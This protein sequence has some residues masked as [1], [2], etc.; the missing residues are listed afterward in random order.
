LLCIAIYLLVFFC[1]FFKASNDVIQNV[2]GTMIGFIFTTV[3]LYFL[4]II[5]CSFEDFN[6]VSDD[7]DEILSIYTSPEEEYKKTVDLNGSH[8][9]VAY[10]PLV[11]NKNFTFKVNDS[12]EGIFQ[13]DDFIT[14]NFSTIF[15]AHNGSKKNNCL[16]VRLNKVIN[17]KD[18]IITFET[19]RSTYYNHLL[20]NRAIDY[21]LADKLTLRDI[22]EFGPKINPP[23]K[24]KMSNHIGINALVFLNDGTL[25]IPR[26]K[27]NST[28]SKKM[29]TSSIAVKLD[30]PENNEKVTVEYLLKDN[31]KN[32]LVTRAKIN[33]EWLKG[34][35]KIIFLGAGQNLYEAGKPQFYY[36]VI[37]N[38]INKDDYLKYYCDTSKKKSSGKMDIDKCIYAVDF[39][40]LKFVKNDKLALNYFSKCKIKKTKKICLQYEKSFACNLWHDQQN[41]KNK[42]K[43][44]SIFE[45]V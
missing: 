4:K 1:F 34:D 27:G 10:H 45:I 8:A 14:E 36:K 25:L 41:G 31:I 43:G 22:Y 11:I 17:E 32:Y 30:I 44:E 18:G 5:F 33:A 20:T 40:S 16:T 24:S 7:T 23:E 37:L 21:R 26:R 9:T 15:S 39:K 3:L 13:L 28:I 35:I 38:D 42:N 12:P 6:K 19:S 2:I 29:L